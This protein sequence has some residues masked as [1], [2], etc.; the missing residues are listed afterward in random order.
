MVFFLSPSLRGNTKKK[1]KKDI[2]DGVASWVHAI[3]YN[4]IVTI[5]DR[6][7]NALSL[8]Y[9]PVVLVFAFSKKYTS[10]AQVAAEPCR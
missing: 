2:V 9:C 7:G 8:G 3:I 10:Q 6:Q 5:P 4:T 1:V